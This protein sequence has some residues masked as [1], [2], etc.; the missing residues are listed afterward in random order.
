MLNHIAIMGR[1]TRDPELRKTPNGTSVAS[2][3]LAVDRDLTP[4]GGEKETDFIDCVAWAGTADFVSGYFF[5]G[6]MAVVDGRLQLRDWKD[7]DGNK[8][9]SAEIVANR[10]Y[11]GEGKKSSEPQNL[12]NPGRFTMMKDDGGFTMMEDDGEELP[13]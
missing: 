10:V 5:K 8:R 11:F 13:I 12:E 2:F 1:M 9:R 7:K 6:S 4:K 3:T